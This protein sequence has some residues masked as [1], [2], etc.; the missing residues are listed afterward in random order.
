MK[1]RR[2]KGIKGLILALAAAALLAPAANAVSLGDRHYSPE[3]L[4]A[5]KEHF[6]RLEQTYKQ[7]RPDDRSG[8]RGVNQVSAQG[9]AVDRLVAN[10]KASFPDGKR[11]DDRGGIRGPGPVETPVAVTS[12]G[13]G[14]DWTDAGIGASIALIAALMLGAAALTRRRTTLAA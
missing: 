5:M 1:H 3:V 12:E 2:R 13:D 9:D 8:I 11:A 4:Q 7:V 6:A 14:F 10:H